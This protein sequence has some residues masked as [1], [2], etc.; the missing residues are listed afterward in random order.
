MTIA[1]NLEGKN[2]KGAF[3][4]TDSGD[5]GLFIA[6]AD[7]PYKS[8]GEMGFDIALKLSSARRRASRLLNDD[9]GQGFS[10]IP[11]QSGQLRPRIILIDNILWTIQLALNC[12]TPKE[13]E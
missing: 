10:S 2:L 12:V 8:Q 6:G 3:S 5:D 11:S 1:A 9:G 7:A 13:L 4:V